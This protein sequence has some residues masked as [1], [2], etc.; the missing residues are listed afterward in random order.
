MMA[1]PAPKEAL[2]ANVRGML[3]MALTAFLLTVMSGLMKGAGQTLP[4]AEIVCIRMIIGALS[5]LPWMLRG[6]LAGVSTQRL[7]GHF[8]RAVLGI[9]AFVLYI[10]A[11]SN[12]LLANAMAL[13]F[14][15]PLWMIVVSRIA[16]G[17]K[18]GWPRTIATL[19]GFAGI[20]IIARPDVEIST[21]ALAALAS[22]F[23]L[24]LAMLYVKRLSNTESPQ[25]LAFYVQVF[26][27]L[28]TAPFVALN[29]Q[30]PTGWDWTILLAAGFLGTLGL[31]GQA[32]AYATGSPTAVA[33]VDFTR[34]P[35]A[36]LIGIFFF[37]ELPNASAF[38]GMAVVIGALVFI[39]R[40]A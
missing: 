16:F 18:A 2:S 14:T 7:G 19:V 4:V 28:F 26:G 8:V 24:S 21:P 32:R 17:E 3:W 36:V 20:L 22:A 27:A 10:Y 12:M 29:W 11:I 30:S 13:T 40:R 37:G 39:S 33:P 31:F 1:K 25:K 34:L 6:G 15:T 9:A 23:L 5:M 38:A 35:I